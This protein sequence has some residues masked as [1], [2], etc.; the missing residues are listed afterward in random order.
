MSIS[1]P[2]YTSFAFI[3]FLFMLFS[4]GQNTGE[5]QSTAAEQEDKIPVRAEKKTILFFG[6][7][8]TAGWGLEPEEG[9]TGIIQHRIDSLGLDYQVINGGLSG[10]TTASGL[11]RLDWFLEDEP[12]IFVLEL[13]GNDGLRGIP[14]AETKNNL[15]QII[16]KVQEKYPQTEILLAGMQIPPNMGKAYS[17]D[18][19]SIFP[20]LAKDKNITLIPFLLEGVAGE[21][22]LNLPDGIHPTKEGH[23][24]VAETVWEYLEPLL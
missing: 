16:Q 22:G 15:Q 14:V 2:Q 21:P 18:F 23:Q 6:N 1:V 10:E 4:C 5:T 20:E 24:I 3:L 11:N 19:R 17:E 8:L 12:Y 9:F 13:G 7:S